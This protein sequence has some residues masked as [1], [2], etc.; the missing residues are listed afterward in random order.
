MELS[1]GVLACHALE[2]LGSAT[3]EESAGFLLVQPFFV[4]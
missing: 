2:A 3:L 4:T 1:E